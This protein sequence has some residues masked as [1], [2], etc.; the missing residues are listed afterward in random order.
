MKQTSSIATKLPPRLSM[1][2]YANFVEASLLKCDRAKA[3]RQ[4]EI[5]EQIQVPFRI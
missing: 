4:K 5:E 3:A 1:D 2:E